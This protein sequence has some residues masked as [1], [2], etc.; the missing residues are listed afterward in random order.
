MNDLLKDLN[1]VQQQAVKETEGPGL[2]IAGAGSGKTR[3]LTYRIAWLLDQGV[4]ASN[5]LAL[6]FTN[7]AAAE[8]KERIGKL[9]GS[10][11]T[12]YLWMGTFHSVFSKILRIESKHTGYSSNYSIYDTQDSR[13]VIRAIIKELG[14]DDQ[15]YKPNV[16]FGRISLVRNNLITAGSYASNTNL[17]AEDTKARRP[18]I[19]EIFTLY[20]KRCHAAD[21]MDFDDLLL[22][23]NILFRDHPEVLAKYQDAFR[24]I[25]VDEYQDTNYAQYLIVSKLAAKYKNISVVGDDA[26]S[27][28]AFRGAR[29]ENILNFKKDYPGHKIYKL[30]QNYRSTKTIVNAANSL[31][32]V[33]KGQIRKNIWSAN[34]TGEKLRVLECATDHEEGAVIAKSISDR[35]TETGCGYD[36]F[37]VL[38]RTNAQSR[39]FEEVLRRQNIPYKVYGSLSFYQRKEIKDLLA[40][41]RLTVNK[42]DQEAFYRIINYPARGIGKTTTDKLADY[43]NANGLNPWDIVS[44]ME[45][46]Q[47]VLGFNRG[48]SGRLSAFG[49]MITGFSE[50]SL[51]SDAWETASRI[52]NMSGILKDLFDPNSN[53][54]IAKYENIQELLNGIKEFTIHQAEEGESTSL[55]DFLQNVSLLTDADTE[56]PDEY[57]KVTL[58]TIHSA[59]GLEFKHVFIGGLEEELFP[60]HFAAASASELE[61]ERRL[62][63]VALTRAGSSATL[64]YSQTRY[65]W[66]VP[67]VCRPSRFISEIDPKFLEHPDLKLQV[68][69]S[70][71]HQG[72]GFDTF[73]SEPGSKEPANYTSIKRRGGQLQKKHPAKSPAATITR[74][75]LIRLDQA[76][77]RPDN[78]NSGITG[79]GQSTGHME[80]TD[81]TSGRY[82][83]LRTGMLVEHERFGKGEVIKIEGHPPNAKATVDFMSH[84]QKQLLLKFA[85]LRQ[86]E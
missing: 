29:I 72:R 65:R 67:A 79:D 37:A 50:L 34:E 43:C 17:I 48:T 84:G 28:Y 21:A 26:Q 75:K 70:S 55:A 69:D 60:N 27:I 18:K 6:T 62:F 35:I 77:Q 5:I 20:R 14:L 10:G 81:N 9:V 76:E 33:N 46:Y 52:A 44:D 42:S 36:C 39:I 80:N 4:P 8:M 32:A 23:T 47:P 24:Y 66:G 51:Q 30:E 58:M 41:C 11:T 74:N 31:I 71:K 78:L 16:V 2:I 68:T 1:E 19:S 82:K 22:N 56:K 85:K 53:E 49:K 40:Y 59:K 73:P 38:Y 3:V 83:D 12:K 13:N 54:N 64:T 25:L 45:K 57:N 63:Y 86:V 7:K 15:L 61:E